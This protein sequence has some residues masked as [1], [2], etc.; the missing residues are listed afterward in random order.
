MIYFIISIVLVVV[1]LL[2][3][4]I[5]FV[6]V[7]NYITQHEGWGNIPM[8]GILWFGSFLLLVFAILLGILAEYRNE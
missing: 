7:N 2:V 6:L 3:N 4:A 5:E 1:S 8:G